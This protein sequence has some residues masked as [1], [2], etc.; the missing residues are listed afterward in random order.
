MPKIGP[1]S[2]SLGR[3][4]VV[5][6]KN[7]AADSDRLE[8]EKQKPTETGRLSRGRDILKTS[9]G[10]KGKPSGTRSGGEARRYNSKGEKNHDP[11]VSTGVQDRDIQR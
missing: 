8:R 2:T 6:K 4:R 10:K 9:R 11:G 1:M 7:R 3:E 5:G